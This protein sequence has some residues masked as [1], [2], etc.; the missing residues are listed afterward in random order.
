MG[1]MLIAIGAALDR[2]VR[3]DRMVCVLVWS[4]VASAYGFTL[5][6]LLRTLPGVRGY[7]PTGSVL[8]F[9]AFVSNLIGVV[10]ALLGIA[11]VIRGAYAA[12]KAAATD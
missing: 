2:L 8:N 10:G 12:L 7:H 3:R 9:L 6:L 1:V 4:E 5:A 11:L